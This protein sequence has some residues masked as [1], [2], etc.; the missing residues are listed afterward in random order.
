MKKLLISLTC[1][2]SMSYGQE[3]NTFFVSSFLES[4]EKGDRL[5]LRFE[6]EVPPYTTYYSKTKNAAEIRWKGGSQT[7]YMKKYDFNSPTNPFKKVIVYNDANKQKGVLQMWFKKMQDFNFK[8]R[9][10]GELVLELNDTQ[11][12]KRSIAT[13]NTNPKPVVTKRVTINVKQASLEKLLRNI[14]SEVQKSMVFNDD[15]NGTVSVN[16]KDLPY[17]DA[18]D[19]ILRPT[20]YRAEHT[21]DGTIIRSAKDGKAF[22]IFHLKYVDANLILKSVQDLAKDGQI[23]IDPHTNTVF[24]ADTVESLSQVERM[25]HE[26]DQPT[27]QVEVES[28]I[29]EL[30]ASDDRTLGFDVLGNVHSGSDMDSQ[31]VNTITQNKISP[32]DPPAA[33]PKGWFVGLTWKSVQGVLGALSVNGKLSV[34]ARPRVVALNDQEASVLIGQKIGYKTSTVSATGG[35]VED[36]K[37]LTVGTQLRLTPHIT[38][39]DDILLKIKPELSDGQ[40]DSKTLV[41]TEKTTTAETKVLIKD[42][43]TIVMGGLLRDRTEKVENKVPRINGPCVN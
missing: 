36:V 18:V 1:F 11:S 38:M 25:L 34:L 20:K 29:V 39:N 26:L 14:A 31:V 32:F 10:S 17:E 6:E 22:K 5:I 3:K 41:P 40:I 42:G 35:V 23:T 28:A 30:Q 21:K 4:D 2:L 15:V 13:T 27:R 33:N 43:Q 37:F 24:I 16:V 9:N 19:T 12:A 7:T 8:R